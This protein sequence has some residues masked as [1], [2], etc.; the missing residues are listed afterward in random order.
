M[1]VEVDQRWSGSGGG[2]GKGVAVEKSKG[3]PG[4]VDEWSGVE[5]RKEERSLASA[6]D[7]SSSCP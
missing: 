4:Q 6:I 5:E 2:G 7:S 1:E 3:L